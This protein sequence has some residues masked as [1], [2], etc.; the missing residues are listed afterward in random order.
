MLKKI[1]VTEMKSI[2]PIC[3]IGGQTLENQTFL[4]MYMMYVLQSIIA[5]SYRLRLQSGCTHI[6]H[7]F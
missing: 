2:F 1:L 7:V 5:I 6:I 3:V 4:T